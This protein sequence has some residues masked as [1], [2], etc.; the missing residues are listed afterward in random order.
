MKIS[1]DAVVD[2][3][4]ISCSIFLAALIFWQAVVRRELDLSATK[5]AR[6]PRWVIRT[7]GA[8]LGILFCW[9]VLRKLVLGGP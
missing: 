8:L 6:P 4:W 2:T 7:I 3:I 5:E 9:V 1:Q